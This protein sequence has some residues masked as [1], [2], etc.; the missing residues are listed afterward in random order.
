MA[1]YGHIIIFSLLGGVFSLLGGVILLSKKHWAD[2]MAKYATPFAAGALLSAVFLDLLKEGIEEADS[3]AVLLSALIGMIAFFFAER[4]LRW[5]HH[6]HADEDSH[7][8]ATAGLVIVGDTL[9]N[10]LD[11]IAIAAS[12][13]VSVPTGI[14]TT[15][16]VAAHEIPQEIG[17]FGL[18]LS[19]GMSRRKVLFVNVLSAFATLVA[20]LITFRLGDGAVLPTGVLLGL[21][22]GFLLYIAASDIIPSIHDETPKDKLVDIRPLLLVLGAVVVGITINLAHAFIEPN[23]SHGAHSSDTHH[24]DEKKPTHKD[25]A[26]DGAQHD[27]SSNAHHEGHHDHHDE[28]HAH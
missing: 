12:F 23:H 20:A 15:I 24:S 26:T 19:K 16:A 8:D 17:D 4:F 22:A 25:T 9:H 2:T 1:N 18:L 27:E 7:E 6:H 21:S 3:Y 10:A 13:L 11:G 5:F 14:I 28:S